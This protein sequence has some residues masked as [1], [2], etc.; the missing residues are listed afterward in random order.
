MLKKYMIMLACGWVLGCATADPARYIMRKCPVKRVYGDEA[1]LAVIRLRDWKG[2][3]VKVI[4]AVSY[5]HL[6]LP[7]KRIV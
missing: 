4:G 1:S 6:T 5:T 7:T 2:G 3:K